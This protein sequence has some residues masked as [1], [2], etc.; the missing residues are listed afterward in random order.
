MESST[1]LFDLGLL[2]NRT[3]ELY[4]MKREQPVGYYT[5]GTLHKVSI[6]SPLEPWGVMVA[7]FS[8]APRASLPNRVAADYSQI[9]YHRHN[10]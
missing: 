2:V 6:R 9:V 1:L 10:H 4:S 8:H 3:V 5:R 7:P